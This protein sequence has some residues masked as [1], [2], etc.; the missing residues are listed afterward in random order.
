MSSP[1]RKTQRRNGGVK[2]HN[3]VVSCI[4]QK[5]NIYCIMYNLIYNLFGSTTNEINAYIYI[6]IDSVCVCSI[7]YY[8]HILCYIEYFYIYIYIYILYSSIV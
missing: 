6:Y 3:D 8:I 5:S 1:E 4:M 7:V 2:D